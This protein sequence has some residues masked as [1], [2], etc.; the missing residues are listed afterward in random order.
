MEGLQTGQMQFQ[1]AK[2]RYFK[3]CANKEDLVEARE[4]FK[5]ATIQNHTDASY[6]LAIMYLKGQ[7]GEARPK[8]GLE[9]LEKIKSTHPD[10][11]DLVCHIYLEGGYSIRRDYTQATTNLLT[12]YQEGSDYAAETLGRLCFKGLED[13]ISKDPEYGLKYF[14]EIEDTVRKESVKKFISN[15]FFKKTGKGLRRDL[16]LS[17][18]EF[19]VIGEL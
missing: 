1:L 7:G 16:L 11:L 14:Q 13:H 4:L 18:N 9:L 5:K 12:S 10:A 3:N 8:K 17:L 6:H 19:R 2:D 15:L